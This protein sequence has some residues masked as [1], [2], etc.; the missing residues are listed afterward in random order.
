MERNPTFNVALAVSVLFHLSMVSVFSIVILLPRSEPR[1]F[2][3]GIAPP[4]PFGTA[5]PAPT[6]A[7]ADWLATAGDTSRDELPL[8]QLPRLEPS[9]P[10]LRTPEDSLKIRSRFSE[11]FEAPETE[12]PD[13]W[14]Q[15]TRELRVIGPTLKQ[16]AW[17]Q[18]ESRRLRLN[19]PVPG[20]VLSIEWF[21]EPS[22]RRV[23][24]MPP[25]ASLWRL[26]TDRLTAP[27][28]VLFAVNAQGKVVDVQTAVEDDAG[29]VADIRNALPNFA[30][31]PVEDAAAAAAL[32]R[33]T[34][35]VDVEAKP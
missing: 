30:F 32:Q 5:L 23:L 29:V 16:W 19:S 28:T 14:A 24:F 22:Q 31:E 7:V 15:F 33:G 10:A 9:I 27:L 26:E 12:T 34:L 13:S 8:V 20:I 6:G 25:L 17:P 18:E 11:L 4:N 2:I 3:L 21:S 1:Q 35:F